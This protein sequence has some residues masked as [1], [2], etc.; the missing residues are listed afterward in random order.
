MGCGRT[1]CGGM[2]PAFNRNSPARCAGNRQREGQARASKA[3]RQSR[4][5]SLPDADLI[6]E[7]R[8]ADACL[9]EIIAERVH[10]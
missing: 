4:N 5:H 8:L 10:G 9:L 3:T 7:V 2:I 6:G 1:I